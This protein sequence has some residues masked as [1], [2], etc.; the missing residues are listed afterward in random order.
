ME[1]KDISLEE[2]K[3]LYNSNQYIIDF[4]DS[5]ITA[6]KDYLIDLSIAYSSSSDFH[7]E[8]PTYITVT[9]LYRFSNFTNLYDKGDDFI[10]DLSEILRQ[11]S[12]FLNSERTIITFD[13]TEEP[14]LVSS[15]Y[16]ELTSGKIESMINKINGKVTANASNRVRD[17]SLVFNNEDLYYVTE[18]EFNKI[19]E[20]YE[21]KGF[22]F[23][24]DEFSKNESS[25]KISFN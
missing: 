14:N 3:K 19:K 22:I 8:M 9:E 23:L 6:M 25:L 2:V 21:K 4:A 15:E 13:I 17:T 1:I 20:Y 16:R 12:I 7:S 18:R 24:V 5:F 10:K 11:N